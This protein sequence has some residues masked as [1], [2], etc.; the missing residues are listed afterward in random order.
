MEQRFG[1]NFSQVR[2]HA[3]Q[4]ADR[5]SRTL[6]AEAFTARGEIYF[7][8]GRYQPGTQAGKRLLAHELAHVV[9]QA[10]AGPASPNAEALDRRAEDP[11]ELAARTVADA[12]QAPPEALR[13][14]QPAACLG[15]DGAEPPAIQRQTTSPPISTPAGPPTDGPAPT[16]AEARKLAYAQ[17]TLSKV[18]AL[19][20]G[21]LGTLAAAIPGA[22]V[23]EL[24]NEKTRKLDE[25]SD[26][27][28]QR[29]L[30]WPTAGTPAPGSAE[31]KQLQDLG[32]QIDQLSQDIEHDENAIQ[33][34]LRGLG[35]GSEQELVDLVSVR[36]PKLFIAR[37]KQIALVQLNQNRQMVLQEIGR[38]TTCQPGPSPQ[39]GLRSAAAELNRREAEIASLEAEL[40]QAQQD[41][42][43]AG[44]NEQTDRVVRLQEQVGA[45]RQEFE[46]ARQT[47]ALQFPVLFQQVNYA[48]LANASDVELGELVSGKLSGILDDITTT[49]GNIADDKLKVWNLPDIKAM[50]IQSLGIEGN[51]VLL[52]AVESHFRGIETDEAILN[53]ALSALAVPASIVAAVATGGVALVAAGVAGGVLGYQLSQSVGQFVAE[54]AAQNVAMDP[55]IADISAKEPDLAW[56]ILDLVAFI[57][58]AA[59]VV[60]AINGL[61]Q[62]ARTVRV[63]GEIAEFSK[64]VKAAELPAAAEERLIADATQQAALSQSSR[65]VMEAVVQG[66]ETHV[67]SPEDYLRALGH[68]FPADFLETIPQTINQIGE[69]AATNVASNAAFVQA[70]RSGNW[71]LAGTLFHSAAATEGRV[72]AAA[73]RL[74][75]GITFVFEDVVQAGAGGSRLDV[76]IRGPVGELIEY[77]WKTTGRS[78]LSSAAR[79]EMTRH[80]AQVLTNRGG[81]LVAQQSISWI[82][83]VRA[84]LTGQNIRW[85][86]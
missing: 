17:T 23:F 65:H 62:A 31:E 81:N 49:E 71:K 12:V 3:D 72:L 79:Q 86:R 60:K 40:H 76:F 19:D 77:D 56:V 55:A 82:D 43:I 36:F 66:A 33:V 45:K 61:R 80:A 29:Q 46:T 10:S 7:A 6:G 47:F 85:P 24:I 15:V 13:P 48:E 58:S 68:T 83:L 52:E 11:S 50:T 69:A 35:V 38:F 28:R 4:A 27:L 21:S 20:P 1:H 30:I 42:P 18:P 54:S 16:S 25:Q 26:L 5:A 34:L 78:A 41:A 57:G 64:A 2:I 8:A 9:Q 37:A 32:A 74:P 84:R 70:C 67:L 14:D 22:Q 44:V 51:E 53:T 75:P 63:A 39:A 59:D 73:G